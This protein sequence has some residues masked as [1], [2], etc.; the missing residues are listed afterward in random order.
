MQA[1]ILAGGLG[2]RLRPLTEQIP[3]VMAPV[4]ER[5]FLEYVIRYLAGEGIQEIVLCVGYLWQK[6]EN[7][8][9]D[10]SR[11]GCRI[12]YSVEAVP[13]GTGGGI[14]RAGPFLR[15]H[16]ILLNGDTYLPVDLEVFVKKAEE[17]S[18]VIGLLAVYNK[19]KVNNLCLDQQGRIMSYRKGQPLGMTHADA[20]LAYY[21]K[22][23]L[24]LLSSLPE[25]FSW[26]TEIYQRLI[27]RHSLRGYP[28]EIPF[29]DIG[30]IE[31][32][33]QFQQEVIF[34]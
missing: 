9:Q 18:T 3:K 1:V 27:R 28:I 7:Y 6:I 23:V 26:E 20:G 12:C 5:P 24:E 31:R 13:L 8:F 21:K 34:Q 29:Y 30:T 19:R 16:F 22:Q 11:F 4:R 25:K 10:G 17:D 2:T 32:L 15:D 33:N 14:K